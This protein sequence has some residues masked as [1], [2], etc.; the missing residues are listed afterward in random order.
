MTRYGTQEGG[1]VG[2]NPQS[3][4]VR[5]SHHPLL[6]F[7][8][9]T[10]LWLRPGNTHSANNVLAFFNA[11]LQRLGDKRVD[12][13]RA[14]SG[15]GEAAFLA[16]LEAKQTHYIVALRLQQPLQRALVAHTGWWPLGE[17]G[18]QGIE[19]ASFDYQSG[20]WDAPRRIVAIRQ[21][22]KQRAPARGKTL[23]L[24][25]DDPAYGHYRY[26]ALVTDLKLPATIEMVR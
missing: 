22:I 12:L 15:F 26:S 5:A 4:G 17:P 9:D 25:G 13:A 11:T 1:A 23:S 21:H 8:A 6:A 2:Y 7:I 16:E 10:H 19:I 18:A 14:D 3:Q 24:F 20:A